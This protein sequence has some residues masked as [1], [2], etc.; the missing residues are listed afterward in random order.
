MNFIDVMSMAFHNL[1]SRK[2]RT[3]LNIIGVV[4]AC[5]VLAMMMAGTRGV[6]EG[7]DRMINDSDEVRRF[8]LYR[9]WKRGDKA[10]EDVT[11]VVGDMNDQRRARIRHRLN[12]D[13]LRQNADRVL[14]DKEHLGELKS[15]PHIMR[16][17]PQSQLTG[18]MTIGD[19]SETGSIRI[20]RGDSLSVS[21][22]VAGEYLEPDDHDGILLGE[23]AAYRMGFV[24][25]D[26]IHALVGKPVEISIRMREQR[27]SQLKKLMESDLAA[28]TAEGESL[29]AMKRLVD[30]VDLTS[31]SDRDKK[32]LRTVFSGSERNTTEEDYRKQTYTIR[33]IVSSVEEGEQSFFDFVSSNN[34]AAIFMTS[35]R[36]MQIETSK[37]TFSSYYGAVGTV[38]EVRNIEGVL[39]QV[40]SMG[41]RTRSS[42]VL[43]GRVDEEIGRARL[44][45][46][47]LSVLILLISAV[48]ISNTMV[49]SVLERTREFGILKAT[50]AQDRNILQLMLMEG[51]LTGLAG[52]IVAITLSLGLA[53][54]IA[55]FVRKYISGR[56]SQEFDASV[57]A[58]SSL[59]LFLVVALAVVV[60]TLASILP[61]WRAAKL[62]PVVAM[63]GK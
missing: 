45:I 8:A 30:A 40:E 24:S 13:W 12:E 28:L 57:F 58:F 15:L 37:E 27:G 62:D 42:W 14:L 7:F 46:G 54:L 43:I 61:A 36:A 56:I 53:R 16:L 31:L 33:G 10:P 9:S 2:L 39:E 17:D 38:D 1:W 3:V 5:V 22:V 18:T 25:D 34:D 48:G 55:V 20:A 59:D 51:A 52:A 35:Q 60:C 21:K 44:V 49:V 26:E 32:L 19:A 4:L 6:A 63:R 23:F 29:T 50:G 47:A 11:K 41:Y